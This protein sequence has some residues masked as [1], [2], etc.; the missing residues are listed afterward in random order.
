MIIIM[1]NLIQS[2]FKLYQVYINDA[3]CLFNGCGKIGEWRAQ[4]TAYE[5]KEANFACLCEEH[6][7]ETDEYWNEMW[8]EY[9]SGLL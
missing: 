1:A 3:E 2:I 4:Q 8:R 5:N 6:Q 7:Q 9:Y